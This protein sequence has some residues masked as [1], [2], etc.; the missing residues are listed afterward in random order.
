MGKNPRKVDFSFAAVL[1]QAN[2]RNDETSACCGFTKGICNQV[3]RKNI[4]DSN[5]SL[6]INGLRT[7][8]FLFALRLSQLI[9]NLTCFIVK[10]GLRWSVR[11]L[12]DE[13]VTG[14]L[15]YG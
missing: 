11:A 1:S 9:W 4:A 2:R 7:A 5:N 15:N 6:I 14:S 12:Y 10:V 13:E 8:E 3:L